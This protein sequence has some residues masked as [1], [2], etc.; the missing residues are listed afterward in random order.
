MHHLGQRIRAS[1]EHSVEAIVESSRLIQ[2]AKAELPHGTFL[3]AVGKA[4]VSPRVAQMFMSIASHE[5]LADPN[6]KRVSPSALP[7]SFVTLSEL[8]RIESTVLKDAFMAGNVHVGLT[9]QQAKQ[10]TRQVSGPVQQ[11]PNLPK[12]KAACIVADPPWTYNNEST[13]GSVRN[14]YD[15]MSMEELAE[16]KVPAAA[17]CHLWLWVTNPLLREGFDLVEAWS[18]TYRTTLTWVKPQIGL[19]NYLRSATEH[20]LFATRNSLPVER[21]DVPT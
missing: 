6:A 13:R 15:T 19:G 20:V 11:T 18:F 7:P 2:A 14:H 16:L 17:D 12:G 10:L 5:L 21:R 1:L 8:S 3:D 9:R 4:G